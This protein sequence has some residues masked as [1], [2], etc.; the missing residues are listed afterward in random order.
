MRENGIISVRNISKI[1]YKLFWKQIALPINHLIY[2]IKFPIFRVHKRSDQPLIT[3][4]SKRF[5]IQGEIERNEKAR[6]NLMEFIKM[7]PDEC[8]PE[9]T[10]RWYCVA[11]RI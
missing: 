8:I 1:L 2:F 11:K 9:L 6:D 4:H 10:F 7:V 3:S 5:D